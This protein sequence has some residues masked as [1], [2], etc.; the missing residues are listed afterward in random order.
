MSR[1]LLAAAVA[2]ILLAVAAFVPVNG[3]T[4]VERWNGASVT[5]PS[6]RPG[7]KGPAGTRTAQSG[8]PS[9]Q[10]PAPE[11]VEHHTEADRSAVDRIVAEHAADP[12]APRR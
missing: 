9:G 2:A 7:P 5:R 4:L 8:L 10:K 12:P 1:L 11:P 3:R 6:P